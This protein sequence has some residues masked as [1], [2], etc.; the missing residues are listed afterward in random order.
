MIL[1]HQIQYYMGLLL[2]GLASVLLQACSL[3][4]P[5]WKDKARFQAWVRRCAAGYLGFYFAYLRSTGS[6]MV[7]FEGWQAEFAERPGVIVSNHPSMLDA[8]VFL[9][10]LPRGLCVFKSSLARN[11]LRG[12]AAMNAGYINNGEGVD[13]L[14]SASRTVSEGGQLVFFP[15]GT[16]TDPSSRA[17]YG[18]YALVAKYALAPLHVFTITIDSDAF[19]KSHPLWRPPKL[20]VTMHVRH[21]KTLDSR[22]FATAGALHVAVSKLLQPHFRIPPHD[23][24]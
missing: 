23:T 15:E 17:A 3:L 11:V 7:R 19:S 13:G 20:P 10:R 21:L 12:P 1:V 6:L 9:R 5:F 16:R 4:R 2:F 18:S 14:R 8:P 22:D 24:V